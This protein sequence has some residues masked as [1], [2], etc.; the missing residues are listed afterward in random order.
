MPRKTLFKAVRVLP[1]HKQDAPSRVRRLQ[2]LPLEPRR[3]HLRRLHARFAR[4]RTRRVFFNI[5]RRPRGGWTPRGGALT[6]PREISTRGGPRRTQRRGTAPRGCRA[7]PRDSPSGGDPRRYPFA[8]L[9]RGRPRRRARA[10]APRALAAAWPPNVR[11]QNERV[12]RCRRRRASLRRRR[13]R[14][15]CPRLRSGSPDPRRRSQR[16]HRL[17]RGRPASRPAPLRRVD[18][19]ARGR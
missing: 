2:P 5:Y 7:R 12:G 17:R 9:G 14:P 18:R 10:E 13:P 16:L 4:R 3:V 15:R 8:R 1:R 11:P 6:F 19:R